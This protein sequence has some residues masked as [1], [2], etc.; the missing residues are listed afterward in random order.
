MSVFLSAVK[1][2]LGVV[3]YLAPGL[4]NLGLFGFG[5]DEFRV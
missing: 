1:Y 4:G 2:F 5:F 3:A